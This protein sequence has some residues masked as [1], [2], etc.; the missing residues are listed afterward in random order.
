[1]AHLVAERLDELGVPQA[2]LHFRTVRGT[3]ALYLVP[4]I[5][6]ILS[7]L[8]AALVPLIGFLIAAVSAV[9][10]VL[11]ATTRPTISRLLRLDS[12][13]NVVGLIPHR[14]ARGA[15]NSA[16]RRRVII[17]AHLDSPRAGWLEHPILVPLARVRTIVALV[18]IV[19]VPV[20][21]AVHLFVEGPIPVIAAAIFS[22]IVLA[23]L[24]LLMQRDIAG[25]EEEGRNTNASGVAV[26]LAIVDELRRY[27]PLGVETLVLFTGA[28]QAGSAGM[29]DFLSENR[30][31]PETTYFINLTSV[32]R[33]P[34]CFTRAEGPVFSLQS[35]PSMVQIAGDIAL[36][37]P[38]RLMRPIE[39]R[40]R[41]TDQYA[42][43]IRG[44]QAIT[45]MGHPDPATS[46]GSSESKENDEI[47]P[48]AVEDAY[49]LTQGI[50]RRLDE[51]S[52]IDEAPQTQTGTP[53]AA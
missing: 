46:N 35:S 28:S 30:F 12:S 17:A 9:L 52:V 15:E 31:N 27:P 13:Q 29:I 36:S 23:S 14:P 19:G 43:L 7:I 18:G 6:L 4:L 22:I 38:Q 8:A 49:S 45:I 50:I 51:E 20:L 44:Y 39:H 25:T 1:M 42:A 3:S 53:G 26:A 16:P 10:I 32:G 24:I 34:I 37:N 48:E 40:G 2:I 33:G 47:D 5:G 41:K 21:L 11:E